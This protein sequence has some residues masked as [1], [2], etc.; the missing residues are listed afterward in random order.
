MENTLT[1]SPVLDRERRKIK[2][3]D[4]QVFVLSTK[5]DEAIDLIRKNEKEIFT[6]PYKD[7]RT[8]E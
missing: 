8:N 6:T 2:E 7:W 3:L 4:Q 1:S 5:I